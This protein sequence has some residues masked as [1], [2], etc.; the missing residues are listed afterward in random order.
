MAYF[1]LISPQG[2]RHSFGRDRPTDMRVLRAVP[3]KPSERPERAR[4]V[5]PTTALYAAKS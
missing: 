2:E 3:T 1:Y 4:T 5:Y